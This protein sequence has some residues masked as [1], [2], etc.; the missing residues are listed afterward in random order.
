MKKD[1]S[2]SQAIANR[3]ARRSNTKKI[4]AAAVGILVIAGVAVSAIT[5]S[6]LKKNDSI[7]LA[8]NL[9]TQFEINT[10]YR[11]PELD[12]EKDDDN[13]DL[14]N[15]EE[16]QLGTNPLD[17]DSD[18]DG[19]SDGEEIE[20][21]TDPLN[22]DTDNDTILDGYELMTGLDPLKER[23]DAI[24]RDLARKT[25]YEIN[26][27]QM[28]LNVSGNGNIA[29]ISVSE[30]NNFGINSN[31]GIVSRAYEIVGSYPFDTAQAT[32]KLDQKRLAKLGV[33]VKDLSF[34][35]FNSKDQRYTQLE[36]T[37]DEQ[38]STITAN[39][40]GY[41]T[42][43][44]GMI[45]SVNSAP[46]TRIAFLL[47]NSGSMY[48]EELCADS[49]EN[50]VDFKRLDFTE[51]LIQKI[52]EQG[53]YQYSIAKF[54][55]QYKLMQ[56]FTKDTS[57]IRDAL[58]H[59][60]KDSEFFDG[61]HI[62]S[63]LERC[64]DSFDNTVTVNTRNIIVLLSDGSSD[65]TG[66]KTLRQLADEADDKNIIIMTV[67]LGS[68]V[69]R[70]WLQTLASET[71]GKYYSAS[72]AYA[73]ENVYRRIVTTLNYDIVDYTEGDN[74]ST[75]YSLYDT[76]FDPKINGFV[77]KNF[78]TADTP[79]V[80][81]GMAMFARDWY[82]GRLKLKTGS[83]EP[84]EKSS[85]K[86]S[87]D[88]YDLTDTDISEKLSDHQTL[89]NINPSVM[90]GPYADVKKYLDYNSMGDTL[91]I[92]SD[93]RSV[94]EAQG[95]VAKSYVLN[96]NNLHWDRVELLSLDIA[97]SEKKI[98]NACAK[99]EVQFYKALYRLNAIQWDDENSTFDLHSDDGF[100]KLKQLLA[101]GEPVITTV[102]GSHTV[103]AI[104]LI[105][106]TNDHRRYILNVYDSN[107][108]GTIKRLYITK[109][110]KASFDSDGDTVTVKSVG[111][112]YTCEYEGKQVGIKF[113]D[114][115]A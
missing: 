106:D 78:R 108:P 76:G 92:R 100:D 5:I 79:S 22:A 112:Q 31:T 39:I 94:A 50:D 69:D 96:S 103:N 6:R 43:V 4:A 20:L 35:S 47:D 113:S 91:K 99:S 37:Y 15:S 48:P 54:T 13:D 46:L 26:E 28:T 70:D 27:D 84:S 86:Y 19:I 11:E 82:T 24:I 60:R 44:I 53:D 32:F 51:N 16:S 38:N 71:G 95:W 73:L 105:Q 25:E 93:M 57:K 97:N 18:N 41:G 30:I 56:S 72:D 17:E 8:Q 114:A 29:D 55:A 101:I 63:A 66:A 23:T 88:G 81:Y 109:T 49:P 40:A 36:S 65:E 34:L 110:V 1:I 10:T 45:D 9:I 12:P 89:S 68:D 77:I 61:T 102:D 90:T 67:G 75:G 3:Q 104:A 111:H 115:V 2:A 107:Y 74:T 87:P 85:Q 21:G 62:Q 52:E 59:I 33:S 98:E 58:D 14:K 80:D 64:M 83:L 42:Y 7:L